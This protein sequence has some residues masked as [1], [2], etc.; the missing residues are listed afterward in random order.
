MGYTAIESSRPDTPSYRPHEHWGRSTKAHTTLTAVW[1]KIGVSWCKLSERDEIRMN[2][3]GMNLKSKHGICKKDFLLQWI[4]YFAQSMWPNAYY[5]HCLN[6]LFSRCKKTWWRS[7]QM[8]H[9]GNWDA[10]MITANHHICQNN[11]IFN[12]FKS[13]VASSCSHLDS[14][15]SNPVF[16]WLELISTREGTCLCLCRSVVLCFE[17]VARSSLSPLR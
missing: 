13:E 16:S 5:P 2:W 4:C 14:M 11:C 15:N 6:I 17:A 1:R 7:K 3:T 9:H 12:I 8:S 10:E